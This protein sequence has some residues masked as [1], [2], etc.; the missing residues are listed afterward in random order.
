MRKHG[1]WY[2][3][4]STTFLLSVS[5]NVSTKLFAS[6]VLTVTPQFRDLSYHYSP[7]KSSWPSFFRA[8]HALPIAQCYPLD[9]CDGH[10]YAALVTRDH[11]AATIQSATW[12]RTTFLTFAKQGAKAFCDVFEI[13]CLS[14]TFNN[15]D[16]P[17]RKMDLKHLWY[18]RLEPTAAV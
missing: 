5:I 12:H 2:P 7:C 11:H 16:A 14:R 17:H 9:T 3:T 15:G 13:S 10:G 8:M 18:I 4:L 6:V 1:T